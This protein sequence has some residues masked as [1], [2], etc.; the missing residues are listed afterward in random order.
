MCLFFDC[1]VQED[2]LK[3]DEDAE[4]IKELSKKITMPVLILWGDHDKVSIPLECAITDS[5]SY[6]R[7][8][9]ILT[10]PHPPKNQTLP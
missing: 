8:P 3:G 2:L 5:L 4:F 1:L 7:F 9:L 6:A 10:T